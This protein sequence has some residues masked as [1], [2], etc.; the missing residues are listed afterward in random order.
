MTHQLYKYLKVYVQGIKLLP[1][2]NEEPT[3]KIFFN[4]NDNLTEMTSSAVNKR[5][6]KLWNDGP[7]QKKVT[8]TRMRKAISTAVRTSHP[9]SREMLASHMNHLP[10]TA[11]RYYALQN[12]RKNALSMTS[13]ISEVMENRKVGLNFYI[14][15]YITNMF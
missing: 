8:A 14:A 7:S 10:G 15:F 2:F 9:S 6:Q 12:R 13:L 11:D 1:N 4:F 5:I 3:V